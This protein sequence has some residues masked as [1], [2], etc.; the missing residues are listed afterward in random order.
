MGHSTYG[1]AI[2][3]FSIAIKHAIRVLPKE[4]IIEY[5]AASSGI[6]LEEILT[7]SEQMEEYELCDVLARALKQRNRLSHS[8]LSKVTP[9]N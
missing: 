1:D 6:N 2:D 5:F 8:T 4:S 3:R 9:L 7:V